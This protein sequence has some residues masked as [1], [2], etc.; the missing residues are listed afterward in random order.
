MLQNLL[1]SR[2]SK[3]K[4]K[5]VI[6][7]YKDDNNQQKR[8]KYPE[9]QSNIYYQI[10]EKP[11]KYIIAYKQRNTLI[12]TTA[13][14]EE[15]TTGDKK[16]IKQFLV[17]NRTYLACIPV[18]IIRHRNPLAFLETS[19]KYT[20]SFIDSVGETPT[21]KH[22][23]LA[24]VH[25]H[26]KDLGYV[27][28][29]GSDSALGA[30]VQAFKE[31]KLIEDNE[32]IEYSGFFTDKDN[33]I[34][35]SNISIIEPSI[36]RLAD[37]IKFL[38]DELK[39][40]YENRLDLLATAIVWGMVAPAIFVLKT[41]N[42]YLKLLHLYGFANSTKSN[43]GK[44]I[45][46]LDGHQNDSKFAMQFSRIDTLARLGE[47]VSKSTFP[48]LVDEVN[49][50]DEKNSWLVNN[51]KS[52]IENRIAR[53]KFPN[54]KASSPIDIPSLS[55]LIFTSNP[56]P[57]LHDSALM[58]RTI[59]RNH[60]QSESWKEDDPKAQEFKEFLRV[61]LSRLKA[62]GDFRNWYVMNHRDEI[63]DDKRPAP[64]DLGLKILKAAFQYCGIEIPT[65]LIEER[66]PENQLEE[67]IQDNDVIVKRAF[68]KYIDEQVNRAL[69]VWKLELDNGEKLRLDDDISDR[70]VRL[71]KDNLLPDVKYTRNYE[72]II[73]KGI[74]TELYSHGVTRDQL[75]NLK[76]LADYM[77]SD[78]R[79]SDGKMVVAATT[80]QLTAYFDVIDE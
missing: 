79:K 68:E 13:K 20:M 54:S 43:T 77:K 62:L 41:N 27:L 44:I 28:S 7:I 6:L 26:L 48:I 51:L 66:L 1:A 22:K 69:Q 21:F 56:P 59:A 70:L 33:K 49:L 35:A 23:T 65:W 17:H 24:E 37:S 60:P 63:L 61:N 14:S 50:S 55:C 19:Q 73:S 30:M 75:P 25:Q 57:P 45:L 36:E 64:L 34:T 40:R 15:K 29:D 47:A 67:S 8:E 11:E 78:Y 39:P 38:I 16:S 31:S 80:A 18:K 53:S 72:A 9:L 58:R 74:L 5:K 52:I 2:Y 10:N 42:Y 71:A 76:A 46:A 4:N 3:N 12:E 32:E